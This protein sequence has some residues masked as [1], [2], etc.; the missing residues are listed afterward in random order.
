[1][2]ESLDIVDEKQD[3]ADLRA[4]VHRNRV[5]RYYNAKVR[6]HNFKIDNLVLKRI[7][8]GHGNL[9]NL[10]GPYMI[11]QKLEDDTFRLQ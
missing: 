2:L 7:F 8:L 9:G 10:G 11:E 5:V 1:M 3:E 6:N 4:A